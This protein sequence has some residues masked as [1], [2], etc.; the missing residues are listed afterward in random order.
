MRAGENEA[1][2]E[3]RGSKGDAPGV[4]VEHGSDGQDGIGLAHAKDFYEAATE[5]ME[6]EGAV[7]IDDAFRAARGAGSKAH[8]GT[9]IFVDGGI[10]KFGANAGEE[11]F[12]TQKAFGYGVKTVG[13][14]DDTLERD[15]F[16]EFFVDREQHVVDEEKAIARVLGDAGDFLGM[17]AEVQRVQDSAGTRDSEESLEVAD[18]VPHHGSD[19]V[20]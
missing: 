13:N 12:V 3:H 7:R 10:L 19:A 5:R 4:G 18:V 11:F 6:H 15:I 1:R 17:E 2:A 20:A 16:A 8:G 9:V 14:D